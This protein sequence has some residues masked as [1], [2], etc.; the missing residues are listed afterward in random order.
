MVFE[1]LGSNLLDLIVKS[2]YTGIPLENV[3]CIIKQVLEGLDFMH[4]LTII[5]TDIKPENILMDEGDLK[6]QTLAFKAL[7]RTHIGLPLPSIYTSNAPLKQFG[8]Y[9]VYI[10]SLL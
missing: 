7:Y 9:F 3:R 1:V 2:N 6:V 8:N 4:R 10:Y 5:H